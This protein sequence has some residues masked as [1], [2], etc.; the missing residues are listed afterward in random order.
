MHARVGYPLDSD[1]LILAFCNG[2]NIWVAAHVADYMAA[3]AEQGETYDIQ[4]VVDKAVHIG[5][6]IRTWSRG[7]GAHSFEQ[8]PSVRRARR[9]IEDFRRLP[10]FE[11]C[12]APMARYFHAKHLLDVATRVYLR[13]TPARDPPDPR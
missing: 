11:K 8:L 9:I 2:L 10:F 4:F 3:R 6:R 1:E 5:R 12:G 13:P 7:T